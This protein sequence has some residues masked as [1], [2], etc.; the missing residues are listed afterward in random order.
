[1]SFSMHKIRHNTQPEGPIIQHCRGAVLK[2][3]EGQGIGGS[4][5]GRSPAIFRTS[6]CPLQVG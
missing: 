2:Q 4:V 6:T 5:T 1:M 3:P